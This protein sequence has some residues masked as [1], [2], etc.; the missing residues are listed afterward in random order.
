MT[1]PV[2]TKIGS[3]ILCYNE[4]R[5]LEKVIQSLLSYVDKIVVVEGCWGFLSRQGFPERSTDNT[6]NIIKKYEREYPEI[7]ISVFANEEEC[8]KQYQVALDTL[9]GI[10]ISWGFLVDADEIY[11]PDMLKVIRNTLEKTP[12]DIFEYRTYSF[13]FINSFWE[14]YSGLYPRIYKI[15]DDAICV[16]ENRIAWPKYGKQHDSMETPPLS[17]IREINQIFRFFHYSY[18]DI[19]RFQRRL[20]YM[21]A[22]S[23]KANNEI[24]KQ[25]FI[26]GNGKIHIPGDL[27]IYQFKGQHPFIMQDLVGGKR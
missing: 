10:K 23:G 17:H 2:K 21:W 8:T 9:K 22:T 4:E 24:S 5:Y 18:V 25:Y 14:Y 7:I 11:T 19:D 13:N 16:T 12:E 20:K 26:D 6:I 1:S 3:F 15:T 27:K